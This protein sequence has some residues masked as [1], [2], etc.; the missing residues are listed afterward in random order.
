VRYIDNGGCEIKMRVTIKKRTDKKRVQRIVRHERL[1][2]K[3]VGTAEKP[4]LAFFRG[5]TT[6]A[7]QVIDDFSAKT[8]L[9]MATNSKEAG[10]KGKN[11]DAA[12][13]LGKKIADKCREKGVT[14]VVFDR[15][16]N[17]FHGVVKAFAD[18]VREAGIKF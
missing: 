9:G 5:S 7:A 11:K 16:G 2:A 12:V 1:R 3:V 6:L 13:K 10:I 4:R 17:L 18:S 14:T 8:I 15:G